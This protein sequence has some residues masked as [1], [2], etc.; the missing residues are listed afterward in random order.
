M[1]RYLLLI[2]VAFGLLMLA[3]GA[4]T[5]QGLRWTISGRRRRRGRL[6]PA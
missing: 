2:L 5:V 4:W 3:L 6:V 1:N